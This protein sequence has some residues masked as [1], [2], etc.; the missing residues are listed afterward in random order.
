MFF[1]QKTT[2]HIF[3]TSRTFVLINKSL[4]PKIKGSENIKIVFTRRN[5][6][7]PA[8]YKKNKKLD[9]FCKH[10]IGR[11]RNSSLRTEYNNLHDQEDYRMTFLGHPSVWR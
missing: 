8:L 11:L 2:K 5:S 7:V 4:E 9:F 10:F 6:K 1:K 3:E